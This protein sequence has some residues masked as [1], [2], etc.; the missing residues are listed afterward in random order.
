MCRRECGLLCVLVLVVALG[1]VTVAAQQATDG[2]EENPEYELYSGDEIPFGSVPI[3][4]TL[5][6]EYEVAN[7]R[8]S[9]M[10]CSVSVSGVP[11]RIAVRT[12]ERSD[13][14]QYVVQTDAEYLETEL[15]GIG[16]TWRFLVGLSPSDVGT[17][18]GTLTIRYEWR[19][20]RDSSG[21]VIPMITS[22]RTVV[23][24]AEGVVAYQGQQEGDGS[25]AA[26]TVTQG[27]DPG[28]PLNVPTGGSSSEQTNDAGYIGQSD[29]SQ[30]VAQTDDGQ[31]SESD[32]HVQQQDADP[33]DDSLLASVEQQY[34]SIDSWIAELTARIETLESKIDYLIQQVGGVAGD[35]AIPDG[36][37]PSIE[38]VWNSHFG[39]LY[40]ITQHG[41]AFAWYIESVHEW[42]TGTI[43]GTRLTVSWHGDNGSGSGTG[44][45]VLGPS[46]EVIAIEMDN[47]NRIY[48]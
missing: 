44:V 34:A 3:G 19:N 48:R 41:A 4:D 6:V 28:S 38:G 17:Y 24:S 37:V 2:D 35:G 21:I 39:L 26:S 46:G 33:S 45:L 5:W 1:C 42:G 20:V 11:F 12:D 10:A 40:Q 32:A 25:S 23:L 47:G 43:G 16:A 15:G 30:H 18:E 22:E 29:S 8:T 7:Y 14:S 9:R 13:V 31:S 27:N 36:E